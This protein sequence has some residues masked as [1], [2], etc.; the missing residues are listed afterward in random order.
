[1]K[2]D[3]GNSTGM[4]LNKMIEFRQQVYAH[5][6]TKAR[7]AQFELID[8]LLSNR[9]IQSFPEL[10]FAP[11]CRRQWH[12]VYAALE[13]GNQDQEWLRKYF[14]AQVPDAPVTVW[15]IDKTVWCHPNARTLQE[16]MYEYSPTRSIKTSVVQGH[17]YS[18]LT[19]IPESGSSWALPI[20]TQRVTTEHDT[21][22]T[23]AE[24]VTELGQQR[25]ANPGIDVIAGDGGYGNHPFWAHWLIAIV[26]S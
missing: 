17:P 15:A 3:Q 1:M 22:T 19:W 5:A 14:I 12:S 26:R 7:D 21:M 23:G 4:Q 9:R 8:A 13:E 16:L 20:S 11:V 25:Q 24:Q 6:L 10:S 2:K 18:L